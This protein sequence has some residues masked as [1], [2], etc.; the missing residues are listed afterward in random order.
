ML[1]IIP[2]PALTGLDRAER[3]A[4][5][6]FV[7]GGTRKTKVGRARRAELADLDEVEGAIG[8]TGKMKV[9]GSFRKHDY[10]VSTH[11]FVRIGWRTKL[12]ISSML[13]AGFTQRI[14]DTM[15]Q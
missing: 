9:L 13:H 6:F 2:L 14:P 7:M 5:V 8:D 1:P 4:L 15:E 3:R 12:Y 11:A 10:V